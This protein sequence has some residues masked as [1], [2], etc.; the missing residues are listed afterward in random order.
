[1][2]IVLLLAFLCLSVLI[3]FPIA[4]GALDTFG[5]E[6]VMLFITVWWLAGGILRGIAE[7]IKLIRDGV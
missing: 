2:R 6:N 4:H 3:A 5:V 7:F 1:M